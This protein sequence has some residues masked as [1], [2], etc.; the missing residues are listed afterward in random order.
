MRDIAIQVDEDETGLDLTRYKSVLCRCPHLM[1]GL[2]LCLVVPLTRPFFVVAYV[3][4]IF[5][6]WVASFAHNMRWFTLV[7]YLRHWLEQRACP[8][9]RRC[10]CIRLTYVLEP[11][12]PFV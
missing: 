11:Q 3:D 2:M 7:S 9:D 6:E 5:V 10:V 4:L 8:Y 1:T 12:F